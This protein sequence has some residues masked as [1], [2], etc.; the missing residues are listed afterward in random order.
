MAP[1]GSV[2]SCA[3]EK[4]LHGSWERGIGAWVLG[5]RN[6]VNFWTALR[7]RILSSITVFRGVE[8]WPCLLQ[9]VNVILERVR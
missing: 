8:A 6:A 1:L 4:K 2:W 5:S 3:E 9:D 7:S